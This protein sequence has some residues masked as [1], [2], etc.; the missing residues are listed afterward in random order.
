MIFIQHGPAWKPKIERLLENSLT[1]G[2]IWDV[3]EE[4]I[5]RINS[6]ISDNPNYAGLIKMFDPKNYYLQFPNSNPKKLVD[7]PYYQDGDVIDRRYLRDNEKVENLVDETISFQREQLF[8]I[9]LTPN[10][11]LASFN[12]RIIDK[13]FDIWDLFVNR[14]EEDRINGKKV[15]GSFIFHESALTNTSQ[16]NEFLEDLDEFSNGLDGVYIIVDRDLSSISSRHQFNA[17]KLSNMLQLIY[18][19]TNMGLEVVIGYTGIESLLYTAVGAFATGTGWFYNLRAFNQEQKGLVPYDSMGRQKKRYTSIKFM[20]ELSIDDHIFAI[21]I[22]KKDE[23]YP[24]ILEETS[25]DEKIVQGNID[26]INYNDI[27]VE[28]FE[29]IKKYV[30]T[31]EGLETIESKLGYVNSLLEESLENIKHYNSSL[32]VVS[33]L[34]KNHIT[35]Y[36]QAITKF[37]E[38]NFIFFD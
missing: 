27:Y 5:E 26:E 25:L 9:Y 3:R 10:L 35:Q 34:N 6:V 15:Y 4:G 20:H 12:E 21:P 17:D 24:L 28:Y 18:D 2:I 23:F 30:D 22:D 14:T 8:D 33:N 16:I 29:V 7:M 11:Y 13:M 36:K 32:Q 1:L 31:I 38:N 19:L 37:S